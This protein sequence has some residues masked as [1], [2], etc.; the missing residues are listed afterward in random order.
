MLDGDFVGRDKMKIEALE[1]MIKLAID[2]DVIKEFKEDEKILCADLKAGNIETPP[3]VKKMIDEWEE[4]FNNMVFH[5]IHAHIFG[6]ETYECLSVS[7]YPEDWNYERSLMEEGYV[8]SHSINM[9]IPEFTES[10]IIKVMQQNGTLVRE[11]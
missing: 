1:R 2:S 3:N 8:M 10:G 6:M 5:V 4:K 9:T 7:C 11:G